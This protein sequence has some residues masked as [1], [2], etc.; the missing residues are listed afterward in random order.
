[1]NILGMVKNTSY[2]QKFD[3]DNS[4]GDLYW[5]QYMTNVSASKTEGQETRNA[6]NK[7]GKVK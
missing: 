4:D 5:H 6:Y 3:V 2:L 1:M 7:M